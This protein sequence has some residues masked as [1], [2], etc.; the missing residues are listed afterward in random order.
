[1]EHREIRRVRSDGPDQGGSRHASGSIDD[2][3]EIDLDLVADLWKMSPRERG[4]VG[5]THRDQHL[6][7]V[8]FP[9]TVVAEASEIEGRA[10]E[11]IVVVGRAAD[12][13]H[14][15]PGDDGVAD[16]QI[17]DRVGVADGGCDAAGEIGLVEIVRARDTVDLILDDRGCLQHEVAIRRVDAAAS[18]I[19][20]RKDEGRE[21]RCRLDE[22][23]CDRAVVDFERLA[24]AD[25]AAIRVDTATVGEEALDAV[26]RDCGAVDRRA[27]TRRVRS[28]HRVD[29]SSRR[30]CAEDGITAHDAIVHVD[31]IGIDPAAKGAAIAR[32]IE[33]AFD[34]VVVDLAVDEPRQAP[35][36]NTSTPSQG[37]GLV[38][39]IP[40]RDIVRQVHAAGHRDVPECQ[41]AVDRQYTSRVL[42]AAHPCDR[43]AQ[44]KL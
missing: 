32:G 25:A 6:A 17:F 29:A 41:V 1:M 19:A 39:G 38:V 34:V 5:L 16:H 3:I 9:Q 42:D 35:H 33:I 22:V 4:P 43:D 10:G 24:I 13:V 18:P 15:V 11:H 21:A 7:E 14:R 40:R 36:R 31:E 27:R 12:L 8:E 37:P 30:A 23:L 20:H 44:W 28:A 26:A 2:V